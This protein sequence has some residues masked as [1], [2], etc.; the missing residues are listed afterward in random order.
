METK[1]RNV[2]PIGRLDYV[3]GFAHLPTGVKRG[4]PS[5]PGLPRK[6]TINGTRNDL[7]AELL[8]GIQLIKDKMLEQ[9][10]GSVSQSQI[11]LSDVHGLFERLGG[12]LWP[13]SSRERPIFVQF[14]D[15]SLVL[16]FSDVNDRSRSV[17]PRLRLHIT[18][19]TDHS[20]LEHFT[21]R[22]AAS[23]MRYRTTRT[24]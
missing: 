18:T 5:V 17:F 4:V 6:P 20:L 13:D 23:A 2:G 11:F 22:I 7:L 21:N 1:G 15:P 8:D 14:K 3:L 24:T 19:D 10:N 16:R 12:R 9:D